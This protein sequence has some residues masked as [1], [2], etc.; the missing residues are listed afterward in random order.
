METLQAPI[1]ALNHV[2]IRSRLH[3]H[4]VPYIRKD[5]PPAGEILSAR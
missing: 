3:R 1:I 4:K 5:I 2:T